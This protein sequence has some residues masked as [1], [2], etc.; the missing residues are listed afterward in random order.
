MIKT[1]LVLV[2]VIGLTVLN[3]LFLQKIDVAHN[4]PATMSPG[5]SE[6]VKVIISKGSVEGFAKF[7]LNVDNGVRIEAIE[8]SGAS[9]TFNDQ[10]AK[11][12]WMSLPDEKEIVIRYRLLMDSNAEGDINIGGQFSYIDDNQRLVYDIPPKVVSTGIMATASAESAE[13]KSNASNQEIRAGVERSVQTKPNGR[14]LV[15]L[16]INKG[17]LSGFAK[18]QE[19]ISKDYT[20]V[21]VEANE[22]VFNIVENSVKF[23][24]FDIPAE[25]TFTVSYEL[26]PIIDNPNVEFPISG[27]FSYLANNET[28]TITIG[29]GTAST[30]AAQ[31]EEPVEEE[32]QL[33][34]ESQE[35]EEAVELQDEPLEEVDDGENGETNNLVNGERSAKDES[36]T[37]EP[38]AEQQQQTVAEETVESESSVS[39]S[40]TAI[41]YR[42]QITAAHNV[43]DK[44][45]FRNMHKYSGT[46]DIEHHEGW[47]KYTT[48]GFTV[49]RAARDYRDDLM[50]SYDFPGPFV[51]AYN[52]GERITVQEAL[53]IANQKWV[54]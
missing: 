9:F 23:V 4:P 47:I 34:A 11:F 39:Q 19:E 8:S 38:V 32:D 24:W 5:S 26:I 54:P 48:G 12:I 15:E 52:E 31:S 35:S 27:E 1:I 14:M 51:T 53:M 45:Y 7:Q 40:V 28:Q 44:E 10:K 41:A 30:S 42:V 49:Y 16:V 50:R 6:E 21:A 33:M 22:A 17:A 13:D 18:I 3:F 46:F 20:A 25:E 37:S 2:N 36:K 29:E 43:V